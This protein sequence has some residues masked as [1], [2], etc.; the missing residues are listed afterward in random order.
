MEDPLNTQSTHD[1]LNWFA[2]L[3]SNA[4][5]DRRATVSEWAER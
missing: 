4:L 3:R 2:L 1:S 5:L